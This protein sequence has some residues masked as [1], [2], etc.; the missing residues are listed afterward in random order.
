MFAETN[1]DRFW[2]A[3]GKVRARTQQ[4]LCLL[5]ILGSSEQ[6]GVHGCGLCVVVVNQQSD[7][8][9]SERLRVLSKGWKD[10]TRLENYMETERTARACR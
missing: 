7:S 9:E 6:L 1:S 3:Y 4:I 2:L 10:V 5:R 8:K